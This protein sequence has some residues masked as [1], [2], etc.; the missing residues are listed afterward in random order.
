MLSAMHTKNLF[1][2]LTFT[3]I[4]SECH[5]WGSVGHKITAKIAYGQLDKVTKDS[6][7]SY[8]GESTIEDASVWMDE[9]RSNHE[10]DY[11]K[12]W[13]YI[14][15]EKG[16]SYDPASTDNIV[17]ELQ[18]VIA[19]L[20]ARNKYSKEQIATDLKILIHLIGDLHQP[21]HVGYGSDKGGNT[22]HLTFIAENSN[23]HKV[24]D[25]EIIKE[26]H[27]TE[28]SCLQLLQNYSKEDIAKI[29]KVDILAWMN[30][31]RSYL[32]AVYNFQNNVIDQNYV[33]ENSKTIEKLLLLSGL[34]ISSILEDVFK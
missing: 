9:V 27:I 8:L 16:T 22:V 32:P 20:K 26:K 7:V 2:F 14:N 31:S 1:F 12:P 34:R 4:Y 10:Y 3:L 30:E 18:R 21:L 13:H 5:A 6:L 28:Q 23:L 25:S 19:E 29:D 33:D 11:Q 24:W 15:I 17:W